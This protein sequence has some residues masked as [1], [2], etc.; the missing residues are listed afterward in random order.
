MRVML[1]A[2]AA[3]LV[4]ATSASAAPTNQPAWQ[5]TIKYS[6]TSTGASGFGN[7]ARATSKVVYDPVGGTYVVRD[8]GSLTTTATF[9]PANLISSAGNFSTYGTPTNSF[10]RLNQ[11]PS[12]TLI[13][14][15]YVDYGQWRR[16][17]TV[18]GTTS[19]ND[20]YLVWGSRTPN[21]SI[22]RSGGATYTTAVDGTF[23][24]KDGA[25]AVA[26]SGTFS[27]SFATNGGTITYSQTATGTKEAGSGT[28]AFGTM[29]GAGSIS[30]RSGIFNG[31]GVTDAEGYKMDLTGN[32]YGPAAQE[33]GGLF[34]ITG[35]GGNGQGAI[36]GVQP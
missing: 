33:I 11:S 30:F 2:A 23:V 19:V 31:T 1:P 15:T 21:A 5:S 7:Y 18:G 10:R 28:I 16:T 32:F 27:A 4:L 34:R 6:T 25:Y 20:T 9:G 14:L 22:P 26:G 13:A 35:N 29:T 8:T 17:S 12:N 24:N 3:V 36:V